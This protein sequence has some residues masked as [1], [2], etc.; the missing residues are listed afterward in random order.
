MSVDAGGILGF[1]N[2]HRPGALGSFPSIGSLRTVGLE[3]DGLGS[4]FADVLKRAEASGA[5]GDGKA[6]LDRA[7]ARGAAAEFVAATLVQPILA[8]LRDTNESAAPFAPGE[9]ERAFGPMLDAEIAERIV[10]SARFS[11]VDVIAKQLVGEGKGVSGTR[12]SMEVEGS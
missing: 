12:A 2:S 9:A 3:S 8:S 10:K 4:R 1:E 6:S 5:A 7:R 11:I